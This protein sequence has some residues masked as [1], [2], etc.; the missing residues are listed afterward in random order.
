MNYKFYR[1]RF[2]CL[3][4]NGALTTRF[5]KLFSEQSGQNA[6]SIAV[7]RLQALQSNGLSLPNDPLHSVLA[8]LS[9]SPVAKAHRL[10]TVLSEDSLPSSC[11]NVFR[12]RVLNEINRKLI[13][14]LFGIT[15]VR[16]SH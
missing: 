4:E 16:D 7:D 15:E 10:A 14:A 3:F 11:H 9:C 2:V 12:D 13:A 6:R 5:A 8:A 1:F